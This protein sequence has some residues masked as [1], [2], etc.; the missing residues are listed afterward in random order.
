MPTVKVCQ[1]WTTKGAVNTYVAYQVRTFV[2]VRVE[3]VGDLVDGV[4]VA[5][6]PGFACTPGG[7]VVA[8]ACRGLGPIAALP[9]RSA[10]LYQIHSRIWGLCV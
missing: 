3:V 2:T 1:E 4:L 7:L 8:E 6:D 10:T 5:T 9:H